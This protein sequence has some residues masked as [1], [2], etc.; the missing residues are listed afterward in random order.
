MN[1]NG[2]RLARCGRIDRLDQWHVEAASDG[3]AFRKDCRSGKHAAVR[4]LFVFEKRDFQPG[5]RER[6]LL[7]FIEILG[8]LFGPLLKNRV[9]Q[10]KKTGARANFGG[11]G[12]GR[13]SSAGC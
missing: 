3:E 11:V 9:G 10:R 13:E 4:A 12:S 7:E 1:T 2:A 8:L 5:L 6:Y